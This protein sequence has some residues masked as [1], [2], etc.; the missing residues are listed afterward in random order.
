MKVLIVEDEAIILRLLTVY[1]NGTGHEGVPARDGV[2]A[3]EELERCAPDM[4]LLD[5]GLPRLSGWEKGNSTASGVR[6]A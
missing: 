4:V 5:I 2:Q 6:V 3:L 1:F